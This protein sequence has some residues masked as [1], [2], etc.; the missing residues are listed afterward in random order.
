MLEFFNEYKNKIALISGGTTFSYNEIK[1]MIAWEIENLKNK[2]DNIAILSGDNFSFVIQFFASIYCNKN[3]YLITDKTRLKDLCCDF[4]I[5][6]T[7]NEENIIENYKFPEIDLQKDA[8]NF[9]TSGSTGKPKSI[10]K[11][12]FNLVREARDIG[13]TFDFTGKNYIVK[14]TTT[15]CHLFGMTFHLMSALCNGLTI[16]T[17]EI[18]YPENVDGENTILVSTPT[19]L[20][21]AAKFGLGFKAPPKYIISAGSKLD[22]K[23]FKILE[24]KSKIIEIYGSSETFIFRAGHS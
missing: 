7:I 20:T 19:F 16:D 22:E 23:V 13:K 11:S 8:V 2:K 14:S 24:E 4:D 5:L 21:S 1:S 9:F 15:M 18:S 17:N 3:I 10:K 12:L 6:E